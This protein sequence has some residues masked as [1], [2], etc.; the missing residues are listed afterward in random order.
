VEKKMGTPDDV[1]GECNAWLIVTDDWGDNHATMRCGLAAKHEGFHREASK[2]F[3]VEW[4]V[5]ESLIC[6]SHG[7]YA[8]GSGCTDC[9]Q[10]HE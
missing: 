9:W 4:V 5:D 2:R 3:T 1:E 7:R 10:E 8:T 6:P